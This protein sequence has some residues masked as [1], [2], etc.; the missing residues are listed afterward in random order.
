MSLKNSSHSHLRS[1]ELHAIA[2][3]NPFIEVTPELEFVSSAKESVINLCPVPKS[4]TPSNNSSETTKSLLQQESSLVAS[5]AAT[6]NSAYL[7][8]KRGETVSKELSMLTPYFKV[9]TPRL[10]IALSYDQAIEQQQDPPPK[11]HGGDDDNIVVNHH[12][13]NAIPISSNVRYRVYVKWL[14][15]DEIKA[16]RS[17]VIVTLDN[18]PRGSQKTLELQD[19]GGEG[20]DLW[21][22][23]GNDLIR[24]TYCLLKLKRESESESEREKESQDVNDTEPESAD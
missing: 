24:V 12:R 19:G 11:K 8:L 1:C 17:N 13:N 5:S 16:Q 15:P 4:I 2:E 7:P 23:R 18:F 21:L 6:F 9:G 3:N 20:K 22:S 14:H 10:H